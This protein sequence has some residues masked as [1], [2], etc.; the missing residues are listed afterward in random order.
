[1]YWQDTICLGFQD[2]TFCCHEGTGTGKATGVEVAWEHSSV[3]SLGYDAAFCT[4]I[5][6]DFYKI[7]YFLPGSLMCILVMTSV[8]PCWSVSV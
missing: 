8:W 2:D 6:L 5:N 7:S 4:A 3:S 1:M